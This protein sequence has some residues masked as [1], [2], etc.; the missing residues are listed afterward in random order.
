[1]A[2]VKITGH[3]SGSGVITVTAPNTS[4]DRT[5]TLPDA[6]GTLLNS[7]GNG[8][9]LTGISSVGGAT[10]VDFN[11]NV[12]ARFGT[13][14]DLDIFHDGTNSYV[15]DVG[16]GNLVLNT[17]AGNVEM[18]TMSGGDETMF[19]AIRN[20]GV[21][22]YHNDSKKLETTAAGATVTGTM[23]SD[24]IIAPGAVIQQVRAYISDGAQRTVAGSIAEITTD[25]R[26][27]ITPKHADSYLILE[28]SAWFCVRNS[29][30]LCYADF[31]D[32]TAS[33]VPWMPTSVGSRKRVHWSM[34]VSPNDVNDFSYMHMRALGTTGGNTNARTYTVRFGTEGV[35]AEFC[36]SDLSSGSG[37]TAPFVFTITEV[38]A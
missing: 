15:R 30:H 31:Y 26:L 13:G 14:N 9:N 24:A 11:D 38:G 22:L 28:A 34:R 8:S 33:A 23:S 21:E 2:K 27:A 19:K 10:G 1:M 12:K 7:D 36:R 25:L 35:T 18:K 32:V 16:T 17:T 6:T 20:G 4:T 3:A 29:T 37:V 5:I